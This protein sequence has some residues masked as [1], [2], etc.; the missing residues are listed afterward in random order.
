MKVEIYSRN[1][2]GYCTAAKRLLDQHDISYIEYMID[3][4]V[5]YRQKLFEQ[6]PDARTV[7]QII[8][9]S[10]VIGGFTELREWIINYPE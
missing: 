2:C 1:L 7:P 3:E 8:I 10:K 5:S 6:V 9:D 4:S